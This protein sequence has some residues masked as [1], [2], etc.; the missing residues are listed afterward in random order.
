MFIMIKFKTEDLILLA[1]NRHFRSVG[2]GSVGLGFVGLGSMANR[3]WVPALGSAGL[4][5]SGSV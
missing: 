4:R 1:L 2:L 3:L 5:S